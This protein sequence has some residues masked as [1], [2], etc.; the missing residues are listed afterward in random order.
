MNHASHW[1]HIVGEGYVCALPVADYQVGFII[2]AKVGEAAEKADY[3]PSVLLERTR[4][5]I[6]IPDE[7]PD[8]AELIAQAVEDFLPKPT[9]EPAGEAATPASKPAK[10]KAHVATKRSQSKPAK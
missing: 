7:E 1:S 6:T 5:K 2:M 4:I 9:P 8:K 10:K 3:Y